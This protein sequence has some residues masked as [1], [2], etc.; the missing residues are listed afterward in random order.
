MRCFTHIY[1]KML[2]EWLHPKVMIWAKQQTSWCAW[3]PSHWQDTNG[4][5][6][7]SKSVICSSAHTRHVYMVLNNAVRC[8]T[9]VTV[10]Q[11]GKL[12][13]FVVL[14][15]T[16]ERPFDVWSHLNDKLLISVQGKAWCDEGDV[17]C[18][19]ERRY[20][21]HWLLVIKSKNSINSSW[22]LRT[23][24]KKEN[25]LESDRKVTH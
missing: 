20:C 21:V 15:E 12:V 19:T 16:Q 9:S 25:Q 17:Q 2:K 4:I 8:L 1:F 3:K 23:D 18:P 13:P 6:F 10:V 11:V 24:W 14:N 7:K 5:L 22:E